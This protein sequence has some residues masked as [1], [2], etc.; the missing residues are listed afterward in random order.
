[1]F[2]FIDFA[3]E[4]VGVVG[5]DLALHQLFADATYFRAA[6]EAAFVFLLDLTGRVVMHPLL[7]NPTTVTDNPVITGVAAFERSEEVQKFLKT[8][9]QRISMLKAVG[10][11]SNNVQIFENTFNTV[12]VHPTVS[13]YLNFITVPQNNYL[14]CVLSFV[15]PFEP[16]IQQMSRRSSELNYCN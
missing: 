16:P 13:L 3:G 11:N 14:K 10:S 8:T 6:G 9:L 4:L 2:V 1:M 12:R 5:L 7:P 15:F